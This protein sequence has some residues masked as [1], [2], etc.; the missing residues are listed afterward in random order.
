MTAKNEKLRHGEDDKDKSGPLI[1]NVR[2]DKNKKRTWAKT[3]QEIEKKTGEKG[4]TNQAII[5]YNSLISFRF[6]WLRVVTGKPF[7]SVARKRYS[8]DKNVL[9]G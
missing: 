8:D 1:A 6:T 7:S 9:S 5:L 2:N 3:I 4:D